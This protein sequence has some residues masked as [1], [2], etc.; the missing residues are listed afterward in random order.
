MNRNLKKISCAGVCLAV[1]QLL[2]LITANIPAIGQ[3]LCPMHIPVLICGFIAG[4]QYGLLIG[5]IAPL[6][7]FFLFGM[8]VIMPNGISMSF[9]LATYGLISGILAL[10]FSRKIGYIYVNLVISMLAGRIVW[11]VVRY[12]IGILIGPN[13]T[14]EMFLLGAFV[15]AIPGIILH[16]III[17][18]LVIALRKA[19]D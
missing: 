13:F 9:E 3:M 2:P 15:N 16:L 11:G 5:F 8:P 7:R 14:V 19:L 1:T 4:W 18:P 10:L 12:L 17:P 6:L